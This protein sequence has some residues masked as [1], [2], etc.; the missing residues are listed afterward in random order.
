MQAQPQQPLPETLDPSQQAAQ[1]SSP[2]A[3]LRRPFEQG[4]DFLLSAGGRA[5]HGTTASGLG[6]AAGMLFGAPKLP[7]GPAMKAG[8]GVAEGAETM[9]P[10]LREIFAKN[11]DAQAVYGRAMAAQAPEYLA[12]KAAEQTSKYAHNANVHDALLDLDVAGR[13]RPI[14]TETGFATAIPLQGGEKTTIPSAVR[15]GPGSGTMNRVMD[16]MQKSGLNEDLIRQL[17][18][19]SLQDA[20]QAHPD[21]AKGTLDGIIRGDSYG[22]VK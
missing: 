17:R 21:M 20:M 2:L 3:G 10:L 5:P 1:D 18:G 7:F 11:P 9:S 8:A 6:A 14:P 4:M 16:Q 15:N 19:M 22:W 13:P 12:G